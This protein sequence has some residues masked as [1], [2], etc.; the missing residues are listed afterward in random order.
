M[1]FSK[2]FQM[3]L[4]GGA[5]ERDDADYV[6]QQRIQARWNKKTKKIEETWAIYFKVTISSQKQFQCLS[7]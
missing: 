3:H 1:Q 6:I 7:K 4:L 5:H 2:L